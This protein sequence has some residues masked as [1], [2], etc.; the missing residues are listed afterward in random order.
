MH[1]GEV[2]IDVDLVRRLLFTQF[3]QGAELPLQAVPSAG[4]VNAIYRLGDDMCVRLPRVHRWAG[5]LENE[6]RWLPTLAPQLPLVV[7]EP[8]ATGRPGEGFPFPW[9]IYRWLQ[10]ETLA[11]ARVGDEREAAA[12]LARFVAALRRIDPS[13]GP[14]SGRDK[15]L[16]MRER[17]TRAAIESLR[18]IIDTDAATAAW[19]ASL[20]APGWDGRPAWTHGDLLPP[21]LLVEDS[22]LSAVI[23]FGNMG[24][25]DPAVDVIAAWSVFGDG[26][27]DDFQRTLDVDDA[28]WLRGR[29]F[30]LHQALLIVPYYPDTNPA[31]VAMAMRTIDQVLADY[32]KGV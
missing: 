20:G 5:D 28:T 27:R 8:L 30:A 1:D 29:G 26:G 23:D 7:P 25:G 16:L 24:I 6:L 11:T 22:R 13:G 14:R 21:N 17:E 32:A 4:T 19:E 2:D 18:G 9:A 10:G 3:P 31:F 12:D 15:P